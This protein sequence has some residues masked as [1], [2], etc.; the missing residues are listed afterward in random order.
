MSLS[1]R[2]LKSEAP[3]FTKVLA[4]LIAW[5]DVSDSAVQST[6]AE[7][8]ENIRLR[9]DDALVEYSNRLIVAISSPLLD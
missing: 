8:L 9:E 5:E 6:V 2:R 1:I 3:D 7:I 4:D